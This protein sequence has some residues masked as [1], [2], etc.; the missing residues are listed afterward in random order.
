MN[1]T[2]EEIMHMPAGRE[3]DALIATQVFGHEVK[4]DTVLT[5]FVPFRV[6]TV[7]WS[8]GF[9][10]L[11]HYSTDIE[12]AWEVIEELTRDH[13]DFDVWSETDSIWCEIFKGVSATANAKTAPLAICRAALL[14]KNSDNR[15]V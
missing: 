12:A 6:D 3:M 14:L 15:K 4:R 7:E 2:R 11:A 8:E 13:Y 1:L 9:T 5:T 10:T